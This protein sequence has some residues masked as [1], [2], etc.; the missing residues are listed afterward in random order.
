VSAV[1]STFKCCLLAFLY[2]YHTWPSK[3]LPPLILNITCWS[4]S[5]CNQGSKWPNYISHCRCNGFHWVSLLYFVWNNFKTFS[6][7]QSC[8]GWW[9]DSLLEAYF[10]ACISYSTIFLCYCSVYSY[11][12]LHLNARSFSYFAPKSCNSMPKQVCKPARF[13][14]LTIS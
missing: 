12:L 6:Y 8:P 10:C 2:F 14:Y 1:N 5:R 3:N 13:P 4:T 11:F 7:L 9:S